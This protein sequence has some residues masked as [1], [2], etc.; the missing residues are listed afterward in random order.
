MRI[1]PK[2]NF[3][4]ES[5]IECDHCGVQFKDIHSGRHQNKIDRTCP[6]NDHGNICGLVGSMSDSTNG[7]GPWYCSR[8][9]WKLK[10]WPEKS[11]AEFEAAASRHITVRE[12]WYLDHNL[13]Y[14]SPSIAGAG[15]LQPMADGNL[16]QRLQSGALGKRMREP[17]DDDELLQP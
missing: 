12:Q 5:A 2:C 3:P 9:F 13:P 11:K 7:Q 10:G 15:L 16:L 6:W 1:C 17:G 8:H 14:E 4:S